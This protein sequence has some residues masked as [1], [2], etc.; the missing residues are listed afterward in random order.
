MT[1]RPSGELYFYHSNLERE[2]YLTDT[3]PNT[4]APWKVQKQEGT[5]FETTPRVL[6]S[7]KG[8]Y[9]RI[10]GRNEDAFLSGNDLAHEKIQ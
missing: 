5:I 4:I 8:Q 3:R 7:N 10:V 2:W 6:S 9:T 1:A